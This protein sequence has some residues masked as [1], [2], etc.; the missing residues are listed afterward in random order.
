MVNC[1]EYNIDI[2][3]K[4]YYSMNAFPITIIV[5]IYR[6]KLDVL[7]TCV[8]YIASF[9]G[10]NVPSYIDKAK[11]KAKDDDKDKDK[12]EDKFEDKDRDK[13]KDEHK[14]IAWN[15]GFHMKNIAKKILPLCSK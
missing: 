10:I 13:D 15:I 3:Y 2:I 1:R 9:I 6:K 12:H 8:F 5:I 7:I 14:N 4:N 11:D